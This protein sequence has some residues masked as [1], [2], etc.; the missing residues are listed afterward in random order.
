[1]Q[2]CYQCFHEY[3]TEYNV[4][5]YCGH[6]ADEVT[7]EPQ[8]LQPGTVL[9]ERYLIG[10]V[11]GAGG[12][13][14]TYAAWDRILEQ[15]VAIKEYLPGEFST[16]ISGNTE[17]TIY[18]GEKTEQF[19]E[20]REKFLDESKRLARM[21]NVSGIVQIYNCFSENGTAYI[22]M[23][24]LEGETL[25]ARLKRDGKMSEQEAL[26]IML[27]VLQSLD[28]VHK[29]GILHRDIAPNNIFLT[30][31]GEIKLLDFGA[32]RSATGSHSK[33]LTVLYKEGYT[34]EEQYRSRGE[35]GPWTDVYACAATLYKM[36]TGN[37][38]PGA[39]E[40]RRKDVM[41][42]PS[43][44]GAKVSRGI[45]AAVMNALNVEVNKRTQSTIKFM[46]ELTSGT[47]KKRYV[48]TVEKKEG[49]IPISVKIGSII[50][51][52]LIGII[53]IL[54]M[55]DHIKIPIETFKSLVLESNMI[56]V[57]NLIN[58][59]LDMAQNIASEVGITLEVIDVQFMEGVAAN[60]ILNQNITSGEI[61][62]K[63]STIE[64]SISGNLD[65]MTMQELMEDGVDAVVVPDLV[66]KDR[67][68]AICELMDLGLGI[69]V[70]YRLSGDASENTVLK[71]NYVAG[72]K[73]KRGETIELVVENSIINW[74]NA[75]P[76]ETKVREL[77]KKPE[78]DIY[79]S[80][81]NQIGEMYVVL[82]NPHA[83]CDVT[84][85]KHCLNAYL[86][87]IYP[88]NKSV[89]ADNIVGFENLRGLF[90]LRTL[91]LRYMYIDSLDFLHK[92]PRLSLVDLTG[93][94]INNSDSLWNLPKL[95][96][97]SIWESNVSIPDDENR[98]K[99]VH[100]DI[101]A[102]QLKETN[103][104][105]KFSNLTEL[106]VLGKIDN[107]CIDKINELPLVEKV[108][109]IMILNK[110]YDY[111]RSYPSIYGSR[112][113]GIINQLGIKEGLIELD[114]KVDLHL[115]ETTLELL[116]PELERR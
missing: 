66:G 16:R 11:V 52:S 44:S 97:L 31:G 17:V 67:D 72:N 3:E 33:S 45:D 71:Q 81:M 34:P 106:F 98:A 92:N 78:G 19:R 10:R 13:G 107:S 75:K 21:Q 23:E 28:M 20:G 76:I 40:R 6:N 26:D 49:R 36:L 48:R 90:K 86:I 70:L 37:V 61:V 69:T 109:L 96:T 115:D 2:R 88:E 15:K 41:K 65:S 73:V 87:S 54:L 12:F 93:A 100:L 22:V 57:P 35:Q 77:L 14:I 94:K 114:K 8:Y 82:E 91:G 74:T 104:W 89:M 85:L 68:E 7:A 79:A 95:E 9:I 51:L 39:L 30:E 4:C 116:F 46:E 25:E 112:L 58:E 110:T 64:V 102:S 60:K 111:Y 47:A 24:F 38:P 32:A 103:D 99:I 29:E 1:M 27:P 56:R 83:K 62:K 43:K 113:A 55:T 101:S 42:E 80:E 53:L 105:H 50:C 59:D 63:N 84:V 5:P 108:Q 18:G